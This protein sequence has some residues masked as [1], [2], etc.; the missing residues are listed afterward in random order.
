M[1]VPWIE[2]YRPT[3]FSDII[4]SRETRELVDKWFSK[5]KFPNMLL[6]GPPGTG[7]TTTAWNIIR[8][9]QIEVEK[10]QVKNNLFS[11]SQNIIS[12]NASDENGVEI[13]R[14]RIHEFVKSKTLFS[15][16]T[17][18]FVILDEI[19]HMTS[20]AQRMLCFIL[21]EYN[22]NIR[23][24]LMCNFISYLNNR[25]KNQIRT[26]PFY[27]MSKER[28]KKYLIDICENENITIF[29]NS[30]IFEHLFSKY[31][32]DIRSMINW[33]QQNHNQLEK[34]NYSIKYEWG[35]F[36]D[37][38]KSLETFLN[39]F[40]KKHNPRDLLLLLLQYAKD[41]QLLTTQ[42]ITNGFK[43]EWQGELNINGLT[44]IEQSN[45]FSELVWWFYNIEKIEDV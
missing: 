3:Q 16:S 6:Y 9:Y 40:S 7:K 22:Q 43:L 1:S 13:I 31:K 10:Q 2:K 30:I 17:L 35:K 45:S 21:Q 14:Q 19:D 11:E 5:K 28:I 12:L 39:Y 33:L 4:L 41:N 34:L 8:K 44:P 32:Y 23:Y 27:G 18:K 38:L 29:N 42:T 37:S 36:E 20:H 26:L 15:S 25:L 24:I